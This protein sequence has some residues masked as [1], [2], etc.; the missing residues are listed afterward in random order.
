MAGFDPGDGERTTVEPSL[1][2]KGRGPARKDDRTLSNTASAHGLGHAAAAERIGAMGEIDLWR[3]NGLARA[4]N[5]A[6]EKSAFQVRSNGFQS[7][8]NMP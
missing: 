5:R 8:I 6:T 2:G 4:A 3:A 1:P 7:P